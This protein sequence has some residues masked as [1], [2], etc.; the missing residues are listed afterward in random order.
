MSDGLT[1]LCKRTRNEIRKRGV[2]CFEVA[3]AVA[4]TDGER[5]AIKGA[6]R[7]IRH[8]HPDRWQMPALTGSLLKRLN[9]MEISSK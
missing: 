3:P 4:R 2:I 5:K 7:A 9:N 1:D 8:D 6:I